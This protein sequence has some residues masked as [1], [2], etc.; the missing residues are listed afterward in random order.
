MTAKLCGFV[1]SQHFLK[2]SHA[3]FCFH[4]LIHNKKKIK[5]KR[6]RKSSRFERGKEKSFLLSW[7][8]Q[9]MVKEIV[10]P[11]KDD[12]T[13]IYLFYDQSLQHVHNKAG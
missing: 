10:L 6:K 5:K 11:L 13:Q 1:F 9:I 4:T 8:L 2:P 3:F 7:M 12:K